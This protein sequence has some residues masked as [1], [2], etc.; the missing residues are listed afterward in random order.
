MFAADTFETNGSYNVTTITVIDGNNAGTTTN[1]LS[2]V[3][4][5]GNY[6]TDGNIMSVDGSFFDVSMNGSNTSGQ[7]EAQEVAYTISENGQTLTFNQNETQTQIANGIEVISDIVSSSV[8][9]R[10]VAQSSCDIAINNTAIAVAA[11]NNNPTSANLCNAYSAALQNEILVCGD[12][13]GMIQAT[14]DGLGNCTTGT[15]SPFA[16]TFKINGMQYNLNN[17]FGNNESSTTNIFSAY[18]FSE[19]IL[20]QSRNGLLGN[21]E[22]DLWIKRTDLIAGTTF[23][24]NQDTM[25]TTTHIDLIDNNN[26]MDET[27]VSGSITIDFVDPVNKIVRGTFEFNCAEYRD[28]NTNKPKRYGRNL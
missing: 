4:G 10:T 17:P 20:L 27:T 23:Q 16:M 14:I 8:W 11:Y 19:Y 12:A 21:I 25:E 24:V 15:T 22:I 6:V 1:V 26:T 2:N 9:V 13:N 7:G 3:S 28:T 18:P 5:S